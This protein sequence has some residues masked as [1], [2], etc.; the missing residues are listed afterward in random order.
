MLKVVMGG[1]GG[2][3]LLLLGLTRENVD[4]LM[5][6]M[7]VL[8]DGQELGLGDFK[9]GIHYGVDQEALIAEIENNMGIKLPA[10]PTP[11]PGESFRRGPQA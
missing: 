4:R 9:V 7:P 2:K 8:V 10:M 1:E 6:G 11:G 5:T 3:R